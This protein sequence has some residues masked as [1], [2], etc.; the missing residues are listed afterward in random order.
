MI[1]GVAI[2]IPSVWLVLYVV[3]GISLFNKYAIRIPRRIGVLESV[4][5]V[6]AASVLCGAT[7][8]VHVVHNAAVPMLTIWLVLSSLALLPAGVGR[9][10]G[11]GQKARFPP[12]PGRA[13]P[14]TQIAWRRGANPLSHP[15]RRAAVGVNWPATGGLVTVACCF[16][17]LLQLF[18]L[19]R[20]RLPPPL[21]C[22]GGRICR[23]LP[24]PGGGGTSWVCEATQGHTLACQG[25]R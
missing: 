13:D 23:Q 12:G 1:P 4:L 20:N 16:A 14:A 5:A 2:V 21:L 11:C 15:R 19:S 25:N 7:Q 3:G 17:L 8:V 10:A 18:A 9:R 22:H 24:S 6:L